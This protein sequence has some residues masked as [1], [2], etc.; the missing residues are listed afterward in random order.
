[1]KK[2]KKIREFMRDLKRKSSFRSA[3]ENVREAQENCVELEKTL[4]RKEERMKDCMECKYSEKCSDEMKDQHWYY[5]H[6]TWMLGRKYT[7]K[8]CTYIL[9]HAFRKSFSS[10]TAEK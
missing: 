5:T 1:M 10:L 6:S 8:L 4:K 9:S 7:F 2:Y 3:I